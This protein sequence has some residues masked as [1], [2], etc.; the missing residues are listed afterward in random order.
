MINYTS[1]LRF[2]N[3]INNNFKLLLINYDLAKI[4]ILQI[5]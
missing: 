5:N 2:S 3:S 4:H 1:T